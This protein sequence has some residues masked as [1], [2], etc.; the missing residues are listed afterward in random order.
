[1]EICFPHLTYLRAS[2][3]GCVI[4]VRGTQEN[5]FSFFLGACAFYGVCPRQSCVRVRHSVTRTNED[6]IGIDDGGD[7]R[8]PR[9][10][11]IIQQQRLLLEWEETRDR[12]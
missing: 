7:K 8:R 9:S 12:R 1:M 11:E 5:M 10:A 6:K 3:I 2:A 4:V